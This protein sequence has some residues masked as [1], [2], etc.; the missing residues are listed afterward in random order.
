MPP[1]HGTV[2]CRTARLKR[3]C[4]SAPPVLASPRLS[5][6]GCRGPWLWSAWWCCAAAI[7]CARCLDQPGDHPRPRAPAGPAALGCVCCCHPK[8]LRL[9]SLPGARLSLL[10]PPLPAGRATERSATGLEH[11]K[12]QQQHC[13]AVLLVC[14][15]GCY[16]LN[17]VP[18]AAN[19]APISIIVPPAAAFALVPCPAGGRLQCWERIVRAQGR[20]RWSGSTSCACCQRVGPMLVLQLAV[21]TP[22]IHPAVS[23]ALLLPRHCARVHSHS[24]FPRLLARVQPLSSCRFLPCRPCAGSCCCL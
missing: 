12:Q 16:D 13:L 15:A 6:A 3:A 22:A 20:R 10:L 19:P 7:C 9:T 18:A 14:Q 17:S 8:P 2:P 21:G 1:V 4:R 24:W 23:L 11:P 5:G